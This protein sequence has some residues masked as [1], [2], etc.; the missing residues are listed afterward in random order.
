[1]PTQDLQG[2]ESLP[3]SNGYGTYRQAGEK[4]PEPPPPVENNVQSNSNSQSYFQT[5]GTVGNQMVQNWEQDLMQQ[6]Q[7]ALNCNFPT[8]D[9]QQM[10]F[11]V[12]ITTNL[13]I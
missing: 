7:V 11:E 8:L 2:L 3:P 4:S 5:E 1:M 12:I 6:N 10:L 9:Q 13:P